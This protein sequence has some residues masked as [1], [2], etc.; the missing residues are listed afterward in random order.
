M[1]PTLVT[2]ESAVQKIITPCFC[3]KWAI[4]DVLQV[5]HFPF[6]TRVDVEPIQHTHFFEPK[7][8]II[9]VTLAEPMFNSS[10]IALGEIW[11]FCSVNSSISA[12]SN[13][14]LDWQAFQN[15][16]VC[17]G[18]NFATIPH[19]PHLRPQHLHKQKPTITTEFW[20][21]SKFHASK[22]Q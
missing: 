6:Q 7:P 17:S 16:V 8:L 22:T 11:W 18:P 9:S 21:D 19:S 2:C 5:L 13:H 14:M 3:R 20:R 10:S 1:H 15:A 12:H 4:T